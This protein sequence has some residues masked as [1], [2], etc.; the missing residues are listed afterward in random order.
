MKAKDYLLITYLFLII[1][2]SLVII[3]GIIAFSVSEERIYDKQIDGYARV[4]EMVYP[5]LG[6]G[7]SILILGIIL[8]IIGV[9]FHW[10]AEEEKKESST[11][12]QKETGKD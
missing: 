6:V 2:I 9:I 4:H 7:L 8:V 5:N 3:G 12:L 11:L 10:R 1:G